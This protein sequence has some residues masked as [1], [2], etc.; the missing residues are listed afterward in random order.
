MLIM[1]LAGPLFYVF[2]VG[3]EF[4]I[5]LDAWGIDGEVLQ[6][7]MPSEEEVAQLVSTSMEQYRI[8]LGNSVSFIPLL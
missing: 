4:L 1:Y 3:A 2:V 5:Q 6:I 8:H 7:K